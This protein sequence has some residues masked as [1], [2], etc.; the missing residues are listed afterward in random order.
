MVL[1][2]SRMKS[3]AGDAEVGSCRA[4]SKVQGRDSCDLA[5]LGLVP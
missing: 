2:G 3:V 1:S 4:H 5:L